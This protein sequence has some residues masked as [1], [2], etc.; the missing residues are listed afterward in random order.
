[1]DTRSSEQSPRQRRDSKDAVLP[2]PVRQ[3]LWDQ[4]WQR[5]L[6]PPIDESDRQAPIQPPGRDPEGR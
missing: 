1:M 4:L 6:S 5:L 2:F 3:R